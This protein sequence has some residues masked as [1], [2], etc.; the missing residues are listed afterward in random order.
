GWDDAKQRTF[1]QRSKEEAN[2][3]R[4]MP[5]PD[6][7]PIEIT[8]TAIEAIKAVFPVTPA[9]LRE[10]FLK[11]K[12]DN[13]AVETLVEEMPAGLLVLGLLDGGADSARVKRVANWLVS[14]VKTMLDDS[15]SWND[16]HLDPTSFMELSDLAETNKISSTGA[17]AVLMEMI[18]TGK[19]PTQIA[20]SQNILQVSDESEILK[21]V[22]QVLSDNP[23]AANDVK[24]GE[25]KAIGFLVGQVMKLSKGKANPGMAQELIKK[26]L[27]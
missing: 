7:P 20:E 4:Y 21:I 12:L 27:G 16:L 23:K 6:L 1:S 14:E 3:Y 5:E 26:Q 18:K 10:H 17:K 15:I 25:V 13:S 19:N 24:S 11:L 9:N 8:Q 22:D 2:D